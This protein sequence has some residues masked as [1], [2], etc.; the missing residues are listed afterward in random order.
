VDIIDDYIDDDDDDEND[1]GD[2]NRSYQ[3][4]LYVTCGTKVSYLYQLSFGKI[5]V[6]HLDSADTLSDR[7]AVILTNRTPCDVVDGLHATC[8]RTVG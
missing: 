2:D 3:I 1:C 8:L 4:V 7:V 6:E 5:V